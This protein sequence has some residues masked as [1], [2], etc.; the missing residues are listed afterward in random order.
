MAYKD[1][2][3]YI[4]IAHQYKNDGI[5]H[6]KNTPLLSEFDLAW[7]NLD[8]SKNRTRSMGGWYPKKGGAG[9]NLAALKLVP[10]I[11]KGA[12]CRV[13]EYASFDSH[14]VIGGIYI[15]NPEHKIAMV[16]LHELAHAAQFWLK[17]IKH[18]DPGKPHGDLWKSIYAGLRTNILN[19]QLEN[20]HKL[21]ATYDE[22]IASIDRLFKQPNNLNRA[23]STL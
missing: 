5:A 8:W 18:Q 16:T 11:E 20:Q 6:L 2:E 23:A 13:Y 17:Y 9:I 10:R 21:K 15:T 1:K 3:Y 7:F 14:P 22:Y 19:P 12:V 4:G